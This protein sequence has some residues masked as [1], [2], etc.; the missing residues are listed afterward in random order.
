M[1]CGGKLSEGGLDP[2][3]ASGS[4]NQILQPRANASGRA[5]Q[6]ETATIRVKLNSFESGFPGDSSQPSRTGPGQEPQ[7]AQGREEGDPACLRNPQT[8]GLQIRQDGEQSTISGRGHKLLRFS[9][10]GG[11]NLPSSPKISGEHRGDSS[12]IRNVLI[13]CTEKAF[14]I[15]DAIKMEF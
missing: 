3:A 6:S 4:W 9:E 7:E 5:A 1:K 2:E 14:G 12:I 11:K 10:G 15:N 13:L 8:S